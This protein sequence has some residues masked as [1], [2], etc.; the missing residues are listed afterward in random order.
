[1]LEHA[2]A[3]VDEDQREV[4][5]RRA[6]D[7]VAR[8]LLVAGGVGDDELPPRR[9]EVAVRHV[10]SDALLAL[11]AQPVGEQREVHV[12]VAAALRG[13]LHVL[14]L[15]LEDRLGVEQEPA[16]QGRLAVI[17]R[18]GRREADEL[19]GAGGRGPPVRGR[20]GRHG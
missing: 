19:G 20:A 8:V 14:E 13:L 7:H 18:A 16:D 3:R 11:R 15:V 10:D 5:S 12:A 1:L 6:G 17:D 2:L 4:G 9:A